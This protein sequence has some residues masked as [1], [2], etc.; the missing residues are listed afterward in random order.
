MPGEKRKAK[1]KKGNG[2]GKGTFI[3]SKI[4]LSPAFL[5]L[6]KRG[7]SG[8]VSTISAQMLIFFLGKRQFATVKDKKGVRGKVRTDS[9]KF[10]LTYKELA[11]HGISQAQAKRGFDELLWKGFIKV[12]D[13]GGC[14][15]RHKALYSLIEDYQN[16]RPGHPPVTVRK[17]DRNQG[18]QGKGLGSVKINSTHVNEGHPHTRQRGAPPKKTH[19]STRGTPKKDTHVN[20]GHS[21]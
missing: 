8:S 17:R 20:E 7:T 15:N 12:A 2:Y 11:S 18:Y 3:E 1:K 6:G 4:F 19:T 5:S 13:P 21:K 16:W 9:N 14:Y 10:D